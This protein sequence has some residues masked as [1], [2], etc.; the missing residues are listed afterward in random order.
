VTTATREELRR[1][2]DRLRGEVARLRGVEA[3]VAARML[4][5]GEPSLRR[6]PPL[7][8]AE[9]EALFMHLDAAYAK[10]RKPRCDWDCDHCREDPL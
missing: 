1:A 5:T 10:A 3:V 9:A 7:Q 4:I 6:V 8:A 2:V